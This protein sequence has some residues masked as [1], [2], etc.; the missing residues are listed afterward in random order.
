MQHGSHVSELHKLTCLTELTIIYGFADFTAYQESMRGLTAVTQLQSLSLDVSGTS[1]TVAAML[2]LTSLTALTF[3]RCYM[4]AGLS[5]AEGESS[6]C[7]AQQVR[8]HPE[9]LVLHPMVAQLAMMITKT[10]SQPQRGLFWLNCLA[11]SHKLMQPI[12]SC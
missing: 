9:P 5:F 11:I 12:G 6:L 1:L 2:P 4:A 7:C 10:C 8:H 3:L